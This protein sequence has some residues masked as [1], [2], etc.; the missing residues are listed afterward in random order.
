MDEY[1][2]ETVSAFK[3][4]SKLNSGMSLYSESPSDLVEKVEKTILPNDEEENLDIVFV[5]DA[6]QSMHDDIEALR[7][8]LISS[9]T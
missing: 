4:I 7:M 6:T 1:N 2:P 8:N 3:E 5:L 9:I